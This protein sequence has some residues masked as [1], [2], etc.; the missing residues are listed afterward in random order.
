MPFD[1]RRVGTFL[2]NLE[3]DIRITNPDG[4]PLTSGD[5]IIIPLINEPNNP[6]ILK[7]KVKLD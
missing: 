1:E 4:V 3:T 5:T 7:I 6:N 2:N